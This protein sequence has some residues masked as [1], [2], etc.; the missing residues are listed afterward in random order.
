MNLCSD[1][2]EEICYEGRNCPACDIKFELEK[3]NAT[4]DDLKDRIGDL[5]NE[6][7]SKE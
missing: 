3:A 5:E 7:S 1:G 4:I 6:L 2:H